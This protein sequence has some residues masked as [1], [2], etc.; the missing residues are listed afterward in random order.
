MAARSSSTIWRARGR[1]CPA[2]HRSYSANSFLS[3]NVMDD[4]SQANE[5]AD[6]EHVTKINKLS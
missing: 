6:E 4:N 2:S 5:M 1:R 3:N